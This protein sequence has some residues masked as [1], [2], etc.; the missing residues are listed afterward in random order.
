MQVINELKA[1]L[2]EGPHWCDGTLYW[3]DILDKKVYSWNESAGVTTIYSGEKMPSAVVCHGADDFLI[4]FED[5]FYSLIDGELS[6]LAGP[7]EPM[8]GLRF[9]DGKCDDAGRFWAGTMDMSEQNAKGALYVLQENKELKRVLDGVTVSNGLCWDAG[10]ETFYYVDS[11]TKRVMEYK[12][13]AETLEISEPRMVYTV[14]EEDVYPDGM[15]IDL[16]GNL[17]LALWNGFGLLCIEPESGKVIKR[18]EVPCKKVTSCCF[19]GPVFTDLYITTA[20]KDMSEADWQKYPD[21]GKVFKC[22]P[23]VVGKP[24]NQSLL[25]F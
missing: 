21:S 7:E 8:D 17:W 10:M 19:G 5:G 6:K 9:N 3:V 23:G 11:A 4:T 12:L 2:G 16:E 1:Q 24:E 22:E 18:I 14:E 13:D 15:S 25:G 20:S